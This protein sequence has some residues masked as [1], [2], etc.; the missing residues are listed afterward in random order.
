MI[1]KGDMI[2]L[3]RPLTYKPLFGKEK[4][5]ISK[6]WYYE[7]KDIKVILVTRG[8]EIVVGLDDLNTE[9]LMNLINKGE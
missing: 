2:R 6:D 4:E 5:I 1:K 7:V 9:D 8:I 3:G